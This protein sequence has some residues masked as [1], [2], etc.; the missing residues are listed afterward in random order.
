[1]IARWR[2]L[3]IRRELHPMRKTISYKM[4]LAWQTDDKLFMFSPT[5]ALHGP[6]VNCERHCV[7]LVEGN[8]LRL[9]L[10]ARRCSVR[11]NS[12]PVKSRCGF[13]SLNESEDSSI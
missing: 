8:D 10:H 7:T 9:R 2:Q 11:T 13:C 5:R 1:M 6:V 3:I 4:N 12:P